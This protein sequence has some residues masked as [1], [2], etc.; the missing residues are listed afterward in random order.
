MSKRLVVDSYLF[1]ELLKAVP[2]AEDLDGV[3]QG[4][5]GQ[6]GA[7]VVVR[8]IHVWCVIMKDIRMVC[9]GELLSVLSFPL[10][11]VLFT[12]QPG[13]NLGEAYVYPGSRKSTE[14]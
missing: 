7:C 13:G 8:R 9:Y 5:G 6:E 3:V 14:T 2:R 1:A 11:S 10:Q 12:I 4:L